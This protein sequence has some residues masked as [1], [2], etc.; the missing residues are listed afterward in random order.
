MIARIW[1]GTTSKENAAAY[2]ELV[3]SKV[4][5]EI[6]KKTGDGFKGAQLLSREVAEKV[7]FTTIIWFQDLETVKRLTGEDFETAHIPEQA[8]KLLLAYDL[9]VTH[10][11]LIFSVKS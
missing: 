8:R 11:H 6:K 1:H 7:E 2:E 9:K 5:N 10:S 4:F 3:T